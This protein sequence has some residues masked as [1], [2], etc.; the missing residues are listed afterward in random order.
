MIINIENI[1]LRYL[2]D[3]VLEDIS[4]QIEEKDKI[5]LVGSNGTGKSSLLKIIKGIISHDSGNI[6][7]KKQTNIGYLPQ[8]ILEF[9]DY[10]ILDYVTKNLENK[11]I[12]NY[13]INSVLNKFGITEHHKLI[14]N[15]SGGEKKR[16]MLAQVLL[17]PSDILLLD[18]PTNHL[19]IDMIYY[20]EKFLIK[21]NKAFILITHDRY[22][23]ERVVN[24]IIEIENGHLFTYGKNYDEYVQL[25]LQK[26]EMETASFKKLQVFLR[27]E[28]EWI[29]RGPRAR[30]TKSK[31]RIENFNELINV[32]AKEKEELELVYNTS[33]LGK[34]IVEAHNISKSINNKLLI[35]DFTY[36]INDDD[37]IGIVGP[38][39]TGKTTLLN[40]ISGRMTVDEG[41]VDIGETVRF[42]YFEQESMIS[43]DSIRVI[44]FINESVIEIN[45]SSI[46]PTKLLDKFLFSKESQY[47]II[48]KLSGGERRRLLLLKVLISNPNV[49]LLDEA[50]NDFD[51]DT[52]M[53][54]ENFIND[55]KG[56][57]IMVSHDRYFLDHLCNKI[58]YIN[59]DGTIDIYNGNYSDNEEDLLPLESINVKKEDTRVKPKSNKL[60]FKEKKELEEIENVISDLENE[61]SSLDK[62]IFK[63]YANYQLV[64][65]LIKRKEDLDQIL[66]DK[67][68]RW[69]YLLTKEESSK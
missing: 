35:C 13:M 31:N 34:K 21:Y 9:Y 63:N 40:I 55:F 47:S 27:K 57:V 7:I 51:I 18:E 32:K 3:Y 68:K 69:E 14:K 8:D 39:G 50:T 60:T 46:T 61:I 10:S 56:P 49:L 53:V 15:L 16:V 4:L 43:D 36:I 23:L 28:L 20:L 38:N 19:D 25:K 5:G 12:D 58:F 42:G 45:D 2:T 65:P 29:K 37:R 48:N 67:I 24:K 41:K 62:D 26:E 17:T 64:E 1:S 54:L 33:R 11:S 44:D 6:T 22:F 66:N 52:I 30:G 59:T